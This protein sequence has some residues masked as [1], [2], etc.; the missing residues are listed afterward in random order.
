MVEEGWR[1]SDVLLGNTVGSF[2]LAGQPDTDD[3]AA[4]RSSPSFGFI[5]SRSSATQRIPPGTNPTS[6]NGPTLRYVWA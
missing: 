3:T 2:V 6:R 5:I 1:H 4:P